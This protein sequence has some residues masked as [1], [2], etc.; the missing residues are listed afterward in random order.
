M[1]DIIQG[2]DKFYIGEN[3]AEPIAEI[4]F[5]EKDAQTINVDHTY[6]SDQLRGQGV[7][8]KLVDTVVAYAREHDLKIEPT[9]P[10]VKKKMENASEYEDV[11]AK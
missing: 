8:G 2:K 10:Y 5:K 3:E 7:A 6:V 1:E 4:T 9:C 11:L